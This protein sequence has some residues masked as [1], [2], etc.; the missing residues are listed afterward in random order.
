MITPV[1]K[2]EEFLSDFH[3]ADKVTGAI[4]L[5]WLG[6]STVLIKWDGKGLLFDPYLSDSLTRARRG[7]DSPMTRISERVIDPL[8]LTGIDLV[9]CTSLEPD[10]LDAETILPLRASN[11]NL[12][13][14]LPAG[15]AQEAEDLLGRAAPPILRVNA[16]T[17]TS[18]SSFDFHGI[19]AATPKIHRDA[20]GHSRELG[21]VVSFGP[22]AIYF[23]GETVWHTNLVKQIR[24]WPINLGILPISGEVKSG[25]RG[26]SLNGFEAAALSKAIS[27]S[28]V[29][30]CDY[31]LF[32]ETTTSP[33]EFSSCCE[34]LGQRSRILKLGQRMTMGPVSDPGAGKALPSDPYQDDWQLGY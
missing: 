17:Y 16:G 30:P 2:N 34:R 18:Y 12:K 21:Y 27:A 26:D 20:N 28:I 32:E 22:F 8:L 11:P 25:D 10:R 24:R 7:T 9:A 33:D 3:E 14:V 31:D 1:Q 4:H 19:E 5:W 13:L 15:A 23:S 6:Q 29:I